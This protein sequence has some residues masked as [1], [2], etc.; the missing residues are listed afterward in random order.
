VTPNPTI[1][2]RRRLGRHAALSRGVENFCRQKVQAVLGRWEAEQSHGVAEKDLTAVPG[3]ACTRE[4]RWRVEHPA[5]YPWLGEDGLAC[6]VPKAAGRVR[7]AGF[8]NFFDSRG[9]ERD[10][11][12]ISFPGWRK[13]R[14]GSRFR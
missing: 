3:S 11:K 14:H 13:R 9:G 8:K 7:A 12:K 2:Q 1:G 6:R 4:R 10:G 5:R